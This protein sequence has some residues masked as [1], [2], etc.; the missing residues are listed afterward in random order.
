MKNFPT[1]L[2]ISRFIFAIIVSILLFLNSNL[3]LILA[4]TLFILGSL[5][6]ALDGAFARRQSTQSKFGAF[7]DPIA[8]K[9]LVFIV[10]I[11]LVANRDSLILFIITI[12]IISREIFIMSLR[13]WVSTIANGNVVKVSNLAKAKTIIQM[14]GISLVIGTPLIEGMYFFEIS[15]SILI[16]GTL[17]SYYSAFGYFKNSFSYIK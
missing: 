4:V 2:T 9:F 5:S 11:S 17:I 10:L 8:D 6:D 15:I 12:F 13:E 14:S 16:L 1:S 3:T 7:L